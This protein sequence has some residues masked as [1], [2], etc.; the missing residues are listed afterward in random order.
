MTKI[1]CISDADTFCL[2]RRG[3]GNEKQGGRGSK[4]SPP[5]S[6]NEVREL[7]FLSLC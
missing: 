1:T 7:G 2:R 6:A 4:D 5:H 3:N